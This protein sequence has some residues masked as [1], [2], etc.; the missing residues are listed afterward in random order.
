MTS[1][2]VHSGRE[3]SQA[4][5]PAKITPPADRLSHRAFWLWL[6]GIL[7]VGLLCR[8]IMLHEYLS[9]NPL[10]RVPMIDAATYWEWAERIA[11]GALV[12]ET[13]FL[14]APLYPYLLGLIRA[15]GGGLVTV[16]VV[17]LIVHLATAG[18]I[19]WIGRARFGSGVGLLATGLFLL[20]TEPAFDSTRLLHSTLQLVL[21]ALFWAQLIRLQQGSSLRGCVAAGALLGLNCLANPPM[22]L[23]IVLATAWVLVQARE[24]GRRIAQ[25]GVFLATALVITGVATLHNWLACG[26]F[27]P[28]SAHAGITFRQGNTPR[29]QGIYTPLRGISTEREQMYKDVVRVYKRETGK[30]LRWRDVDAYFRDQGLEY[31]RS[32]PV[33]ALKLAG[34][35]LYLFLTA[36][37]VNDIYTPIGEFKSGLATWLVRLSPLPT[38]LLMG[39]AL[40]GLLVM[41]RRPVRYAPE[42]MLVVVPLFVA[43]VFMYSPRYRIPVVPVLAV[44]AAWA[45]VRAVHWRRHWR[46]SIGVVGAVAAS[47]V[48]G[49]VD[50]GVDVGALDLEL[51]RLRFQLGCALEEQGKAEEAIEQFRQALRPDVARPRV[52]LRLGRALLRLDRVEQACEEFRTAYR[53]KPNDPRVAYGLADVLLRQRLVGEA[54]DVLKAATQKHPRSEVAAG[55]LRRSKKLRAELTESIEACRQTL[56]QNPSD[57]DT[58][59]VLGLA[60]KGLQ[61]WDEAAEEFAAATELAPDDFEAHY[62]LGVALVHLGRF[63]RAREA[64]DRALQLR[65]DDADVPYRVAR[66]HLRF[67]RLTRASEY[68]RKALAI[69]PDHHNARRFLGEV[70]EVLKRRSP[71]T[72]P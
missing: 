7:L 30:P 54:D 64:F 58:R 72:P 40:V 4:G 17:Q 2:Q 3:T 32:D 49:V 48:L 15:V 8:V 18:L 45:L 21:V 9:G 68:L 60:L 66:L 25:A 42:W 53:L 16:Y 70:E 39:P 57:S 61:R 24:W 26:E 14:S 69:D 50:R 33:G 12:G 63:D 65:P 46:W 52:R 59:V 19:G 23:L 6:I 67:G 1:P 36:R 43:V 71:T 5:G 34:R 62:E 47:L 51:A 28:V 10:A 31:W 27:I 22:M 55:L 56:G 37:Y 38:A 13:P 44:A 11:G 29:S 20:A 35:K 41:L